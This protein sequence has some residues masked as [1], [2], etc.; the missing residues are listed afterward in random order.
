MIFIKIIAEEILLKSWHYLLPLPLWE[1][2]GER[3]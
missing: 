1:R 2:V 3:G